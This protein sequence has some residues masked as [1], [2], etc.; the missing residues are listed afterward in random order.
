M[1]IKK[2]DFY[3]FGFKKYFLDIHFVD[4]EYI[5]H[6]ITDF[7][8]AMYP[9]D[10]ALLY[11]KYVEDSDKSFAINTLY[12]ADIILDKNSNLVY[13]IQG[14]D[15]DYRYRISDITKEMIINMCKH[16]ELNFDILSQD[17]FKYLFTRWIQLLKNEPKFALL[18]QDDNDWYDILPFETEE[19]MNQFVIDHTK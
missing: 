10:T 3:K 18:Y 6:C 19:S 8:K 14:Y 1:Y 5:P 7:L 9:Y 16:G 15:N 12:E 13:I 17:N 4:N 2:S 11:K